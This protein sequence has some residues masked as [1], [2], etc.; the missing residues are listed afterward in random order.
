MELKGFLIT[1][2]LPI[3][4][5]RYQTQRLRLARTFLRKSG[6]CTRFR[7][8][9]VPVVSELE[10]QVSFNLFTNDTNLLYA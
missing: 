10:K 9:I 4:Y 6:V 2:F 1:G 7:N 3:Q 5:D 8:L